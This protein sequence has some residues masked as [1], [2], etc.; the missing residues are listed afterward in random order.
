[1]LQKSSHSTVLLQKLMCQTAV[2]LQSQL[3]AL[4]CITLNT[5]AGI[6]HAAAAAALRH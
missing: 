2:I 5:V 1:V 6:M 4:A 3:H